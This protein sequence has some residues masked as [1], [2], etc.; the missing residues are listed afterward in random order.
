VRIFV[1]LN[2]FTQRRED[3]LSESLGASSSNLREQLER[4]AARASF[5]P[6]D[7][8][9]DIDAIIAQKEKNRA[10]ARERTARSDFIFSLSNISL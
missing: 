3:K 10:G 2:L 8:F 9:G 6:E 7:T 4:A 5:K 1:F